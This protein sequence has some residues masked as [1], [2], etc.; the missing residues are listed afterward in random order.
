MKKCSQDLSR[1]GLYCFDDG[2][3]IYRISAGAIQPVQGNDN[4]TLPT[5][6]QDI[7]VFGKSNMYLLINP[8]SNG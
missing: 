3:S 5:D 6:I 8:T 7:G 2:N 1:A 4:V